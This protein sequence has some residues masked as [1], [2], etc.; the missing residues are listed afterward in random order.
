MDWVALA[1]AAVLFGIGLAV[2]VD[3]RRFNREFGR[4]T[5]RVL[6]AEPFDRPTLLMTQT[7]DGRAT[8]LRDTGWRTRYEFSVKGVRRTAEAEIPWQ[9]GKYVTVWYDRGNPATAR[10]L[11]SRAA[12]GWNLIATSLIPAGFWAIEFFELLP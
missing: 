8:T 7:P 10:L 1:F 2:L 5:G 6:A 12:F 4:T 3:H 9:P 11:R